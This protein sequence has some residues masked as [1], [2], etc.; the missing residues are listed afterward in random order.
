V[1]ACDH[2]AAEHRATRRLTVA[3]SILVAAT[4]AL[5]LATVL[6]AVVTAEEKQPHE[7]SALTT[8]EVPTQR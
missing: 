8:E 6:L 5:V 2:E 7:A 1:S 4:V 3:S